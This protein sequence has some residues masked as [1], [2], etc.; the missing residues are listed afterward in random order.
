M[1]IQLMGKCYICGLT[2][3]FTEFYKDKTRKSGYSDKCISCEKERM[4]K[5]YISNKEQHR[6]RTRKSQ[7]KRK[8]FLETFKANNPCKNCDLFLPYWTMDFDHLLDKKFELGST[9][10]RHYSLTAIKEEMKKCDLVCANCHTH[11]T[12]IRRKPSKY[13]KK[14]Y[15]DNKK[16]FDEVKEKAG[17]KDCKIYYKSFIL[18]FD[19]V[20]D[21]SFQISKAYDRKS[22]AEI[23][24]ETKKC[25]IVCVNCHRNRT[26]HRRYGLELIK[27]KIEL[28]KINHLEYVINTT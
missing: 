3:P 25:D 11:R 5:Y 27:L 13:L 26:Y 16:Y 24:K 4:H 23:I 19:H 10:Y 6:D 2:K 15:I 8:K 14:L 22:K 17:C 9:S 28:T 21:K 7:R 1:Y 18:Q 12:T 20:Y